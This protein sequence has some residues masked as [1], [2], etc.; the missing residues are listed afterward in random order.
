M[1]HHEGQNNN[2]ADDYERTLNCRWTST[3]RLK[4]T[5]L[6]MNTSIFFLSIA[7]KY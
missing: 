6:F 7:I 3:D 5:D 1:H 2:T 4:Q